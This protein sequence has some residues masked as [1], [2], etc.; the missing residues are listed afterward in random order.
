MIKTSLLF[1]AWM[2]VPFVHAND[3]ALVKI[4]AGGGEIVMGGLVPGVIEIEAPAFSILEDAKAQVVAAGSQ[5]GKGKVIAFSHGGFLIGKDFAA[6]ESYLEFLKNAIGW[7]TNNAQKLTIGVSPRCKGVIPALEK[8]GLQA[9]ILPAEKIGKNV[10]LYFAK[11][12]SRRDLTEEGIG[13][14]KKHLQNGGAVFVAATPWPFGKKFPDFSDFPPNQI[15]AGFGIHLKPDG[16]ATNKRP[17]L[18]MDPADDSAI[19]AVEALKINVTPEFIADLRKGVFLKKE[20]Q[21]KFLRALKSLNETVGPIIPSKKSPITPG[22]NLLFDAIIETET[23]LNLRLPAGKMYAIPAS[24]DYPG[25]IA[26]GAKPV[27]KILKLDAKYL[28]WANGRNAGGWAAGELRPTGIYAAPGEIITVSVLE[29]IA[30]QGF[31][32]VI[33]TYNGGLNNRKNMQRYPKL[34]RS[35]PIKTTNTEASSGLG[36]LVTI[37]VPRGADFPTQPVKITGGY[38]AP[39]YVHGETDLAE[40]KATIRNHPAP[41]AELA[42]NRMII[43]VPSDHI[44]D[45]DDPDKVMEA[46]IAY[47]ETA[48][49]LAVLDRTKFRAERLI[50]DRQTAAGSMH[51]GYPVAAHLGGASKK[52]VDSKALMEEGDWGFFHEYGHNHQHNLWALPGTGE[53]TCNLWSV[54][55]FEELIGKNRNNTHGAI[56]PL[57][58]KTRVNKYFAD[59][60]NFKESWSMWNALD[61]FLMVQEEFGWDPFKKVFA[62][63]N[64][65]PEAEWPKSQQEKNDQ[66]IIRLSKACGKNLAPFW[67]KW[68]LPLTKKVD[69]E[70]AELEVWVCEGLPK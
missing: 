5:V 49:E 69:Q 4:N 38:A 32:V 34:Q 18:V 22:E 63:Y 40:W 44:R 11:G 51:S 29:E 17:L 58:R 66:F 59:G 15:A 47:I 20:N 8:L 65:L 7:A 41:W 36:G 43:S 2:A 30:G 23:A 21:A 45:L 53:T 9:A 50:F 55:I 3:D 39:L 52:A 33:G 61:T 31:D 54:Y 56:K 13:E 28:G 64:V 16:Y 68:N 60:A 14:I 35:F 6:Q 10:D 70:L 24:A 25:V 1:A 26:E 62:E 67:R 37:R 42:S 48:A 57:T 19:R 46:W 12:E 27:E